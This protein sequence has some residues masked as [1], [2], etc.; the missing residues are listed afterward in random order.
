MNQTITRYWLVLASAPTSGELSDRLSAIAQTP[1][2]YLTDLTADCVS[3]YRF[4]AVVQ[5]A[6]QLHT[7]AGLALKAL[8]A[9]Q[10]LFDGRRKVYCADSER[11]VDL[12]KTAFLFP[13]QGSQ[14]PGMLADLAGDF[15]SVAQWFEEWER[16]FLEAGLESPRHV[17]RDEV[18][19]EDLFMT[20]GGLQSI[21]IC[22]LAIL[23]LMKEFQIGCDG[24]LGYSHGENAGLVASR[25]VWFANRDE[26]FRFM[27][28]FFTEDSVRETREEVS[29]GANLAVSGV[30]HAKLL[31]I[32]ARYGERAELA[33]DN[34]PGHYVVFSETELSATLSEELREAGAIVLRLPFD[35]GYHTSTFKGSLAALRPLYDGFEFSTPEVPLYSCVTMS[36][37]STVPDEIK[38]LALS[39][40]ARTVRFR[41]TI[42]RMYDDGYRTF[43][44]VGPGNRLTGYVSNTLGKRRHLALATNAAN[45]SGPLQFRSMCAQLFV[46]GRNLRFASRADKPMEP[47]R[48]DGQADS[49]AELMACHSQTMREFLA[50]QL[51]VLQAFPNIGHTASALG[52]AVVRSTRKLPLGGRV[53]ARDQDSLE[54]RIRLAVE[55]QPFLAHHTLGR[56]L[57][58][59]Q[60]EVHALPVMPF[61]FSVEMVAQCAC[62]LVGDG[63]RVAKVLDA[64]A[65]RW[66]AIDQGSLWLRARVRNLDQNTDSTRRVEVEITQDADGDNNPVP[67]FGA[68]VVFELEDAPFLADSPTIAVRNDAPHVSPSWTGPEFYRKY[69]F[70][71]PTFQLLEKV[72]R[73]D[74]STVEGEAFVPPTSS[75][76]LGENSP[77]LLTPAA[78]LDVIGHFVAYWLMENR[79]QYFG[80]FPYNW[81]ETSILGPLPK[82]GEKLAV[83]AAI[84]AGDRDRCRVDFEIVRPG[85]GVIVR[86]LDVEFRYI[87]F[88]KIL[89]DLI[90]WYGPNVFVSEELTFGRSRRQVHTICRH[91]RNIDPSIVVG[92]GG[93]WLR[94]MAFIL[95]TRREREIWNGFPA[96]SQRA[97]EWLLGRAAAKDALREWAEQT[98]GFQFAPLDFEIL[99]DALGAPK[100]SLVTQWPDS[101][102]PTLPC[103]SISHTN[104]AA[105]AAAAWGEPGVKVGIDFDSPRPHAAFRWAESALSPQEFTRFTLLDDRTKEEALLAVWCAKESAA[106]ASG[107]GLGGDPKRWEVQSVSDD[108]S[109]AT[110]HYEG[111]TFD[112]SL[113]R[114]GDKQFAICFVANT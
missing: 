62:Q 45:I 76:F 102:V 73:W 52:P 39:Q 61:S 32:L 96:G 21:V 108:L 12:A 93:V 60:P 35:Y 2:P 68:T 104:G 97:I 83:R 38:E 41:E 20:E 95:L 113:D 99:P 42:E 9:G 110:I 33:L 30:V 37:F 36:P 50:S 107:L 111:S 44:E 1:A 5:D 55:D 56:N 47:K 23:D 98:Y 8:A 31:E 29:R 26:I 7:C 94:A 3:R 100:A 106:K 24:M 88:P 28:R 10:D 90:Y 86:L 40:W 27:K 109:Q 80:L 75:M 54:T 57:S 6:D 79:H 72:D 46:R 89:M 34:C 59:R 77:T 49:I 22:S 92:Q 81:G 63:W 78:L 87:T 114:C 70:H 105:I 66:I 101:N 14:Y 71:G 85:V 17:L 112:V 58:T 43:V 13:G 51:R 103:V 11:H 67:V 74:E 15:P 16:S 18:S 65:G 82:P 64:K 48:I 25:I 84:R 69:M 19:I 4:A 53:V 91:V